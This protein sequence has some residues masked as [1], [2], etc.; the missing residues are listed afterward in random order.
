MINRYFTLSLLALS[1]SL[2]AQEKSTDLQQVKTTIENYFEGYI[3]RDITKLRQAFDTK[4]GA[5]KVVIKTKDGLESSE[6]EFFKDL[7]PKW[8]ARERL[9]Q[10][11]LENCTLE[12]LN[13]DLVEG[14]MG[15]AK[16]SLKLGT[17]DTFVDILSLQKINKEWKITNKIFVVLDNE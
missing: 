13:I 6:N 10:N 2:S 7:I 5:M 8:A 1:F 12:I 14:K 17:D 16:I 15:T 11:S 4:N 3:Y 9:S